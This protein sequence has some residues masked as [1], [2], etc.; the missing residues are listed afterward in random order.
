MTSPQSI[1]KDWISELEATSNIRVQQNFSAKN[2]TSMAVGGALE[3]LLDINHRDAIGAVFRFLSGN[4]IAWRCIGAGSNII[5]SDSGLP[6]VT[7]RFGRG[8]NSVEDLGAG[9]FKIETGAALVSVSATLSKAGWSGLEFAAGIPASLGGAVKMNAGAHGGEM[10]QVIE[11][12]EVADQSGEIYTLKAKELGFA[13]RTCN[14][15][16]KSIV[17]SVTVKLVKG[18]ANAILQRR[19]AMLAERKA[20]QP[21]SSPSAGSVFRNPKGEFSAGALIEACGLKGTKIGGA[22]ISQLHANW[23]INPR[24]SAAAKD[25]LALRDRAQAA[26]R[27]RFGLEM[28]SEIIPINE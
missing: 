8:C 22:E 12:I 18:D 9:R 7:L 14:L 21:L 20:R 13:Y 19:S 15:V 2:C 26:V 17:V 4:P 24:C 3:V 10:A 25:V 27:D 6:G 16:P 23:I 5:I 11:E 28:E 1:E